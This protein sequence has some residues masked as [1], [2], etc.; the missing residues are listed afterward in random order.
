MGGGGAWLSIHCVM[1]VVVRSDFGRNMNP[2]QFP[3]FFPWIPDCRTYSFTLAPQCP[4]LLTEAL[5]L[6]LARCVSR[7]N[8]KP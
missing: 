7:L 8:P 3:I 4:S 5:A 2:E 6:R 1:M